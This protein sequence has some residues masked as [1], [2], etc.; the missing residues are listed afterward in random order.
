MTCDNIF[1]G[2]LREAGYDIDY[3]KMTAIYRESRK[4]PEVI[5]RK[6]HNEWLD[7]GIAA[8]IAREQEK[9]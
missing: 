6:K 4:H 2:A 5:A 7:A 1:I 8:A 9:T 3:K